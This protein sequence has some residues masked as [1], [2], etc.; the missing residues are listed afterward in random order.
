MTK[1]VNHK[2][3]F[4]AGAATVAPSSDLDVSTKKYVDDSISD[5]IL[6]R[7]S[8]LTVI[9]HS[10]NIAV[11]TQD[12]QVGVIYGERSD[13]VAT[14]AGLLG[15][16]NDNV[17]NLSISGSALTQ[18]V[19]PFSTSHAGWSGALQFINPDNS[20]VHRGSGNVKAQELRAIQG[21][22]LI[23]HGINDIGLNYA[24]YN[25]LSTA[26]RNGWKNALR[27]VIS[28]FRAAALYSSYSMGTMAWDSI[29]S[30]SGG[31]DLTSQFP[32]C[33][34]AG[35]KSFSTNG[36]S[37]TITLPADLRP[38][39][40]AVCFIGQQ[41][42]MAALN[43]AINNSVTSIVTNSFVEFPAS[44]TC[45][46]KI[47]SEEMLVTAG[48]GTTT[49]TVTRGVN[50][51][52]AASHSNNA[53][54][55]I[56]TDAHKVNWTT[57]GTNAGIT[58]STSLS[59]QGWAGQRV[60][61]VKR[62]TLTAA[63]AGKTIV[64]TVAGIVASDTSATVDFDSC[65]M[66]APEPPPVIVVNTPRYSGFSSNSSTQVGALNTDTATVVAEFD[67]S[68]T[69]ADVDTDI[70]NRSGT[71]NGATGTGG[72]IAF[73]ANDKTTFDTLMNA[74][75]FV[76]FRM[77]IGN[78][79][80]VLVTGIAYVSGSNY[81]LTVTR[82]I[83]GSATNAANASAISYGAYYAVDNVHPNTYGAAYWA[84]KILAALATMSLTA[85]QEAL[86]SG[87]W[88][89]DVRGPYLVNRDNGYLVPEM[90]AAAGAQAVSVGRVTWVPVYVPK[91]CTVTEIGCRVTTFNASSTI[92][93]GI[94]D[95]DKTGQQ[96]GNLLFTYPT[97]SGN[98]PNGNKSITGLAVRLR[99][100][101]YWLA[102][103]QTGTAATVATIPAGGL[104]TRIPKASAPSTDAVND[105]QLIGYISNSG[106]TVLPASGATGVINEVSGTASTTNTVAVVWIRVRNPVYA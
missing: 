64:A 36:N 104:L 11:N 35:V 37:V 96:P 8:A 83:T 38:C 73:T 18:A 4:A 2:P 86:T 34:G 28:R 79:E 13:L 65:W 93:L 63:D 82:A 48:F 68:V 89:Q 45:V 100:G 103:L 16:H 33:T 69:I 53:V 80:S 88:T 30:F 26:G 71:A 92:A 9:G 15:I 84:K 1:T 47:D 31:S 6:P 29:F 85:Q 87:N 62:F 44:G 61:V 101:W 106:Q 76:P 17:H 75:P 78:A 59:G 12:D 60:P 7:I 22:N 102:F 20:T 95:C 43:G 23:N 94:Y 57:S 21:L 97:V 42:A 72:T 19:T 105:T 81:T 14:L 70:Y 54:I 5:A 56:A 51:T 32:K 39:V 49:W 41:N 91:E 3:T 74:S 98:T 66:E 58:G 25:F 52:T 90:L 99:P 24:E 46:I 40:F 67:S 27:A 77:H 10:Y 55:T 50:G